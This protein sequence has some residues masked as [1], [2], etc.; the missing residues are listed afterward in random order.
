MSKAA[1]KKK[2]EREL[3]KDSTAE[4]I[5]PVISEEDQF[6]KP[7]LSVELKLAVSQKTLS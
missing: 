7:K 3:Y 6:V 4:S 5:T 2:K 1:D